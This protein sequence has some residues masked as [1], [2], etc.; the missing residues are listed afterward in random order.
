MNGVSEA[1][2]GHCMCERRTEGLT[3]VHSESTGLCHISRPRYLAAR[4]RTSQKT[5]GFFA[6]EGRI[7]ILWCSPRQTFWILILQTATTWVRVKV[8][9]RIVFVYFLSGSIS[10]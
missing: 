8:S 1:L 5:G 10:A 6:S 2:L 4:L 3:L 7:T 9:S